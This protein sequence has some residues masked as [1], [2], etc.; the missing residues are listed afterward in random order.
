MAAGMP[1]SGRQT[2][3]M[4]ILS[5]APFLSLLI[6]SLHIFSFLSFMHCSSEYYQFY[7]SFTY[8]LNSQI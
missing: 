5:N 3:R 7:H 2:A 6:C 1:F 4:C 8:H